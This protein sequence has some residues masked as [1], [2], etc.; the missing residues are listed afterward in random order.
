MQRALYGVALLALALLLIR[1]ART[2]LAGD[3]VDPISRI[4]TQDEALYANSAIAMARHGDW[5]TPKFMGRL[6]LYKP[7]LLIWASALSV[8]VLGVSRLALRLPVSL[9][10]ALAVGLVFLFSAETRSWQAGVCAGLL[11]ASNHLWQVLGG[12]CMTDGILVA[13]L[14]AAMYCLYADPWLESRAALWGFSGA[15]AGAILT[16]SVAGI[17]PLGVLGLYWLAAPRNYK[18]RFRR[19]CLAGLLA[20]A[21]ASPWF[22]F[23]LAVH[24]RWFLAEHIQVEILG[25]GSGAPP[26]TS[27]ENHA[28]F[29]LMRMALTDP[30]LLAVT[31]VALPGF[32][33]ALR[34]RAPEA[35][36]L[37]CWM[38]VV[39]GSVTVWEYRNA[40]YLLPLVPA[41]AILGTSY[42]PYASMR[43]AWWM[44]AL[45]AAAVVLKMG[46]PSSPAG[47]SFAAGTV[48]PVAPLVSRYCDMRRGNELILIGTDDDLYAST[49]PLARLRY[50][51]V[52]PASPE[53]AK[54]G[55]DFASMGIILTAPQFNELS[56]LEPAFRQRL[57]EWGI[58]S[59]EPIGT[60]I[61]AHS[62][63]E[64]ATVIAAHPQSDFL[65]PDSYR[66]VAGTASHVLTRAGAGHFFLLSRRA[67]PGTPPEWSCHL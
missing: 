41:L 14:V 51:M 10:C 9:L 22:L 44:V 19:V 8:K 29:Y 66:V 24:G 38:A 47:I 6:A 26:Q 63:E 65:V 61:V 31:A 32:I 48:Q 46:A 7:P 1:A 17:L 13:L 55:M 25:F 16:K 62:T 64:M 58:E 18:P 54:Y 20:V 35:T 56:R 28:L 42:G 43:P 60:L 39:V 57:R 12:S 34:R 15:V 11:V 5:L 49:L 67:L 2:G 30:V 27:Q 40:S 59:G 37:L 4:T 33:G 45:T 50:A 52:Q 3:Y 53:S 36:L 21:L 23:Q